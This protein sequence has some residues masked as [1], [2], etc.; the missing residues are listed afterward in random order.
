MGVPD[1]LGGAVVAAWTA[2]KREAQMSG[3][4]SGEIFGCC[5]WRSQENPNDM[6]NARTH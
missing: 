5:H 4:V 6:T 1:L 3:R 2:D